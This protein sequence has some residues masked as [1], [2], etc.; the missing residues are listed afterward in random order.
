MF[1]PNF[2][3]IFDDRLERIPTMNGG[4]EWV[5]SSSYYAMVTEYWHLVCFLYLET[6]YLQNNDVKNFVKRVIKI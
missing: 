3:I 6:C 5:W 1:C 2:R 4:A